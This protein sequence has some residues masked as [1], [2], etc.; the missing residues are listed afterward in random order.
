[1]GAIYIGA[2]STDLNIINI[3]AQ[4]SGQNITRKIPGKPR[5]LTCS[6]SVN[7]MEKYSYIIIPMQIYVR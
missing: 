3:T 2:T 5:K 7:G 4:N 6:N 1:M